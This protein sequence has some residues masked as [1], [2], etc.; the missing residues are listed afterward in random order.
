MPL[1]VTTKQIKR[2]A[3]NT[4]HNPPKATDKIKVSHDFQ[5]EKVWLRMR[6]CHASVTGGQSKGNSFTKSVKRP[7]AFKT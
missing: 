3:L 5:K 7:H 4:I 1:G 2:T 6:A